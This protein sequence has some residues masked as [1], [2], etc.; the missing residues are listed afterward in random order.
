MAEETD[1]L[2]LE[3]LRAMRGENA[4]MRASQDDLRREMQDGFARVSQRI[5]R[6]E[7]E[8]RGLSY[9]VSTA[10][11]AVLADTEDLKARVG[12]LEERVEQPS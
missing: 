2:A 1:N 4:A 3:H 9:I 12:L 11:G 10:V 6:L 8:L 7:T 5:D